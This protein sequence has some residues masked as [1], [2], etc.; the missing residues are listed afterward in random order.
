MA[1]VMMGMCLLSAKADA[2]ITVVKDG[3]VVYGLNSST[4]D[5]VTFEKPQPKVRVYLYGEDPEKEPGFKPGAWDAAAMRFNNNEGRFI[6]VNGNV[7]HLPYIPSD[8][9]W[10][11][12]TLIFDISDATEDCSGRVMN[13]WWSTRYD[14]DTDVQFTNGLWELRLT[15]EIAEDCDREEGDGKDLVLMITSGSCV[16]KAVYYE[17]Y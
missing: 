9:Y 17:V 2:Q 6:D 12:R 4:V 8:V 16:I 5:Y 10:S 13:G 14:N 3:K 7:G 15:P 1:L 11:C